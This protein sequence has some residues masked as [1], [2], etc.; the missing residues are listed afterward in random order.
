[1]TGVDLERLRLAVYGEHA[2][3][4]HSDEDVEHLLW[5]VGE[6]RRQIEV[7][8]AGLDRRDVPRGGFGQTFTL[9][10]RIDHL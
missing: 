9:R 10:G 6:M 4:D 5:C 7:A 2:A 8:H 1:V 3:R